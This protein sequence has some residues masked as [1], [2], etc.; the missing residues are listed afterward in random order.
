MTKAESR[1]Y[2]RYLSLTTHFIGTQQHRGRKEH[3]RFLHRL[4]EYQCL[5]PDHARSG[6]EPRFL[7][8]V[9]YAGP[10]AI[11]GGG[12]QLHSG[13]EISPERQ[14]RG[15]VGGTVGCSRAANPPLCRR[16]EGATALQGNPPA[17]HCDAV[18]RMGTGKDGRGI[19]C[20]PDKTDAPDWDCPMKTQ[21]NLIQYIRMHKLMSPYI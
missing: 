4:P 14:V 19:N 5:L 15:T 9:P 20:L 6:A 16:G 12:A 3:S 7:R 2:I 11:S 10:A 17:L 21:W 8:H 1:H 13:T 18:L